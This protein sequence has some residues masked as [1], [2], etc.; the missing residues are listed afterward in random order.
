MFTVRQAQ[1]DALNRRF[2]DELCRRLKSV[3]P[4]NPRFDL[5]AFVST[6]IGEANGY[7]I[8]KDDDVADY[9]GLSLFALTMPETAAYKS[10]CFSNR[11]LIGHDRLRLFYYF[12]RDRCSLG[13]DSVNA[14]P[15]DQS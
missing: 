5:A 10:K 4:I 2:I 7:G 6:A 1:I 13:S 15:D 14:I 9:V 3:Y 12:L 8:T 11:S